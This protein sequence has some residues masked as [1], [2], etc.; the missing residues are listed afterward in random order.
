MCTLHLG[1]LQRF[2][3]RQ[4]TGAAR[5]IFQIRAGEAGGPLGNHVEIDI[6]RE[7]HVPRV[8]GQDPAT[9]GDVRNRHIDEF[10]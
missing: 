9:A 1:R 2:A 10:V 4:Q 6:F 3:Q 8:N 5:E 7:R